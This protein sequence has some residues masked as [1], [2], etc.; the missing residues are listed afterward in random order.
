MPLKFDSI[1]KNGFFAFGLFVIVGADAN[2]SNNPALQP[3]SGSENNTKIFDSIKEKKNN[4]LPDQDKD[5]TI[6]TIPQKTEKELHLKD[7]IDTTV[8]VKKD[9]TQHLQNKQEI[10]SIDL[11]I[12]VTLSQQTINLKIDNKVLQMVETMNFTRKA[13]ILEVTVSFKT[14]PENSYTAYINTDKS[15]PGKVAGFMNFFGAEIMLKHSPNKESSK[16]FLFD[17]SDKYKIKNLKS[18]LKLLLVNDNGKA[19]NEI[20]VKKV[21]LE[22]RDF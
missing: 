17:I 4:F 9:K 19:V 10:L 18:N 5:P 16:I 20:A 12:P 3:G 21:R 7:N 2:C 14:A 13:I 1:F 8:P 11:N 15:D 22:T 6:T